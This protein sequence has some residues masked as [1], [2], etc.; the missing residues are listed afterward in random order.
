MKNHT[1]TASVKNQPMPGTACMAPNPS[2]NSRQRLGFCAVLRSGLGMRTSSRVVQAIKA[3]ATSRSRML[4]MPVRLI[5][6]APNAGPMMFDSELMIWLM[7]AMRVSCCL[8][9]SSGTEACMAGVW[10]ADP[11]ERHASST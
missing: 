11:M 1:R 3:P 2:R 7:P 10:K 8:G 6:R 4:P 5:S 9:A